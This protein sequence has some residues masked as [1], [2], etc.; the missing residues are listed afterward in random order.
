MGQEAETLEALAAIQEAETK[1]PQPAQVA[2]QSVA[3]YIVIDTETSDKPDF[4]LPADAPGQARLAEFAMVLLDYDLQILDTAQ[5]YIKPDGWSMQPEAA[6]VNGLTD[7]F[8]EQN[9]KPVAV[10][11]DMYARAI[12]DGCVV[13]AH[14]AQFDAKI[15]RGEF[16]RAHRHDWFEQTKQ[17]CTMR[18]M[19]QWLKS[20]GRPAKWIKLSEAAAIAGYTPTDSHAGMADV[21]TCVEV[22]RFLHAHGA[23]I[24]P[25]VHYGFGSAGG[26]DRRAAEE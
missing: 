17:T 21:M 16:R 22:F 11:L 4:K 23:V 3:K 2:K 25:Q 24:P 18:S 9:G 8:L 26:V 19:Q 6:A 10:A 15:M 1:P 14:N 7:K 5:V 20:Q 13:V 12:S